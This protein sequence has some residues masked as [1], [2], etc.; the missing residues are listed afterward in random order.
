MRGAI[1]MIAST[2]AIPHT[3]TTRTA[4]ATKMTNLIVATKATPRLQKSRI[5]RVATMPNMSKQTMQDDLFSLL[6][7]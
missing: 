6:F 3:K 4:I 1:K 5:P 7:L 2:I